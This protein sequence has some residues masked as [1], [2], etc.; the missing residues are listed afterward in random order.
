MATGGLVA[1]D[2]V[3]VD[4]SGAV[5]DPVDDGATA[6]QLAPA[7]AVAG[8]QHELGGV[9]GQGE[10]DEALGGVGA[11]DLV[12]DATEVGEQAPVLV[13][14]GRGLDEPLVGSDVHADQLGVGAVGHAGPP[15][16]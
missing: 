13:E 7:R 6:Q 5:D 2:D 8:A 1:G 15:D 16:G 14:A 12:V 3:D 9:L 11:D 4:G 10:P